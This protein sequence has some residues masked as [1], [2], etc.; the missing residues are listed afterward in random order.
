MLI[1]PGTAAINRLVRMAL[2]EDAP[3]GTSPRGP[4]FRP[5]RTSPHGWLPAN[6]A[7]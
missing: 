3:W 1:K 5:R 7:S 4:S 2:D 6:P